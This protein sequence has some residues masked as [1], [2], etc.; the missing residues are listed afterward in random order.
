MVERL[1]IQVEV[2]PDSDPIKGV[3]SDGTGEVRDFRGWVQLMAAIDAA[4]SIEGARD[5]E[6]S[7]S[8]T[9]A[10]GA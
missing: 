6:S 1:A 8:R 2:E 5:E 7:E 4:R 3:V 9:K 10:K